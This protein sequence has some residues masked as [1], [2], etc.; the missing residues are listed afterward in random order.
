MKGVGFFQPASYAAPLDFDCSTKIA[1]QKMISDL[2]ARYI[3][4][5]KKSDFFSNKIADSSWNS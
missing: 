3:C 1:R 4:K 5:H 2:A